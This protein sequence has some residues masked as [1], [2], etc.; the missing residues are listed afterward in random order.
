MPAHTE[1]GSTSAQSQR[2]FSDLARI[3]ARQAPEPPAHA[4]AA[5]A[6]ETAFTWPN[7]CG[8]SDPARL[9]YPDRRWEW[10]FFGAESHF[11]WTMRDAAGATLDGA[12]TYRLTLPAR[13]PVRRFWS[14]TV[15]DARRRTL[16]RGERRFPAVSK[17]T[18][19]EREPDGSIAL[20]FGPE[21]IQGRIGNWV[22]AEPGEGWFALLR[23]SGP[24]RSFFTDGWKPSDL[25]PVANIA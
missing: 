5:R 18:R 8:A 12:R 19:P 23:F 1:S 13:I 25:V 11:L 15:C 21:P 22:R 20:D 3:L 10:A 6:V 7:A 2:Y 9:V 24:R 4:P 14:V 17:Y 16:M